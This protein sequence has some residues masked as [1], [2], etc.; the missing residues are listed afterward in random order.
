MHTRPKGAP[1]RG[2]IRPR[3]REHAHSQCA[4]EA[5]SCWSSTAWAQARPVT[6][7]GAVVVFAKGIGETGPSL[8]RLLCLWS[9]LSSPEEKSHGWSVSEC[10][11]QSLATEER[12]EQRQARNHSASH[13]YSKTKTPTEKSMKPR[14]NKSSKSEDDNLARPRIRLF[15][16]VIKRG[17]R[18]PVPL[19]SAG[20]EDL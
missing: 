7:F 4:L 17:Q 1:N 9:W 12:L 19:T 16:G 11:S 5:V 10:K 3:L 8:M 15:Y 2:M 6:P 13:S 18:F 20:L 14:E